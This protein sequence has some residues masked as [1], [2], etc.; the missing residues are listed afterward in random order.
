MKY[1]LTT[2]KS[3]TGDIYSITITNDAINFLS[4]KCEK[5]NQNYVAFLM[6][7]NLTDEEV[8]NLTLDIWYEFPAMEEG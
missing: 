3:L 7:S 4:F 6:R 8:H 1:M 5:E 2:I